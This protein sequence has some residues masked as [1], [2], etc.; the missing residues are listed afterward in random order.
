MRHL[1]V[2]GDVP[3]LLKMQHD[4]SDRWT[5]QRLAQVRSTHRETAF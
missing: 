5:A 3:K 2:N 4:A 1:G